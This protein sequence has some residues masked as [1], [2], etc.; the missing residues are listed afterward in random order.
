MGVVV[1]ICGIV[2]WAGSV[3][4]G[5]APGIGDSV[6]ALGTVLAVQETIS[7]KHIRHIDIM[8]TFILIPPI[9]DLILESPIPLDSVI[10]DGVGV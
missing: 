6:E 9:L 4:V 1:A 3:K 8:R 7:N 2:D 5:P 10:D